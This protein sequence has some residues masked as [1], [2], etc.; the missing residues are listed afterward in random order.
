MGVLLK[1]IKSEWGLIIIITLITLV[2]CDSQEQTTVTPPPHRGAARQMY[3]SGSLRPPGMKPVYVSP[4]QK[5][6]QISQIPIYKSPLP[7]PLF[8]FPIAIPI[9]HLPIPSV[10]H[11]GGKYGNRPEF[12]G[13]IK[14]PP[15]GWYSGELFGKGLL[16]PDRRRLMKISNQYVRHP[17]QMDTHDV[18]LCGG[19]CTR[20]EFL[21]VSSCMCIKEMLRCDGEADCDKNEDEIDCENTMRNNEKCEDLENGKYTRCP[22]TGSC[23]LKSWLCDG[24]DDCGDYTDETHCGESVNCTIDQFECANGLCIPKNWVCDN[25]NDCKDY[26]DESN[27]TKVGCTE[28][29]FTCED[30]SCI[31]L[32]WKCDREPDCDD[33]TD[34]NDCEIQPFMCSEEEFQCIL[35]N[36]CI[37][38]EYKCDG[39]NDCKDWSDEVDCQT[40]L[41]PCLAGEFRC[42][43]GSCIPEKYRCDKQQDCS[44]NEDEAD[45]EHT[46]T[47]I[48]S[49][50]EH[51][52]KDGTCIL[53]TWVCDGVQDCSQ[54]EDELKCEIV[55]DDSKF[56]CSGDGFNDSSTSF[57]INKKHICDGQKDCPKGEDEKNCSTKKPCEKDSV[58]AQDCVVTHDGKDGC[59]CKPGY[60]L[61]Q[62]QKSCDDINECMYQTDPVCSQTCNNTIGSFI[63]GCMTGYILRPDLRSCKALGA[64]PTLLFTNRVD[65]RQVSLSNQKYTFLLKGLHNAIALDYHY[66]K[67]TIFWSDLT[68]DVIKSSY[69]NGTNVKDV[70]KWGL[71]SPGGIALDWVHNLLFWTDSGTRR[72]EVSTLEG[73]ERVI[74]AANDLDKPR[75]ISVHPGEALIFWT[76]WGP[77]P[78]IERSEMDGTNRKSIITDSVFWPNGL[79]LDYTSNR[80]YWADAKHNVIETA[81]FDGSDRRK[82]ISKGLPHPFALTIFEDAIYWTDWHTKSI[83][84]ANKA[85]GAGFRTIH[86]DLHFPMDI[87]SYHSLRQPKYDNHCGTNNGGCAHLCLPN[88]KGFVCACPMG[89]KLTSDGKSCQKPEKLLIFAR[90]KELRIKHLD[91]NAVHSH[92]IIIP[93]DGIK[94]AVALDWDSK[95]DTVFWTDIEKDTINSAHWNGTEQKVIIHT[96]LDS[97][98]GLAYDWITDKIY[99]TDASTKRIEVSNKNGS[100]RSLLIWQDLDKPQD[101]VVDPISGFMYWS[102][103]GDKPKIEKSNMDGSSRTVL[104]KTNISWPNGLAI[105]Y[106][107]G[108]LYWADGKRNSIDSCNLDGT[109]RKTILGPDLPHPFGLDIFGSSLYWTDWK[110]PYIEMADKT[111]GANRNILVSNISDLMDVRIFHRNRKIIETECNKDNG[112]C[113]HLCLLKPKGYSC[114]C[115]LGRVL[116]SDGKTCL[117]NPRESLIL[118][119]RFDIRQISLDV[120]YIIDVVLPFPH[121]KHVV[122]TDFDQNSGMLYWSDSS[123]SV[124]ERASFDGSVIETVLTHELTSVE[125]IAIDSITKK[126]YW[127]D[128]ER[129]S[130]EVAELNGTNRKLL[131][132]S[133][134]DNPRA[135]VLDYEHGMMVWSDWGTHAKIETAEMDGNNRKTIVNENLIWPNGLAIDKD[136]HRIYWSDGSAKIIGSVD[137]KGKKRKVIL[138]ELPHPYG[139]TIFGGYV[140]WTD[141]K[142]KSLHRANKTTG[143]DAVTLCGKL[144]GL[145]DVRAISTGLMHKNVCGSNNGGCSHLCLRNAKGYSCACPTGIKMKSGSKTT[146]NYQPDKYLLFATRSALARI[147]L[148]SPDSWDVTLPIKNINHVINVDFHWGLQIFYFTDVKNQV[149][150]SVNMRNLSDVKTIVHQNGSA[151]Y[152][153]AIDWISNNIYWSDTHYS[154]IQVCKMDGSWR[155]VIIKDD[156]VEPR[157]LAVYPK[158]GYLF[159]TEW[160]KSPKIQRSFLDG[161]GRQTILSKEQGLPNGLV[162]DY[163]EARLYWTDSQLDLIES[164]DLNGRSSMQLMYPKKMTMLTRPFGLALFGDNMYWTDWLDKSLLRAD[165]K[166]GERCVVIRNKLDGAM[167][168]TTVSQERQSGWNPCVVN[169]GGCSHFCFF[170][171]RNYTCGCPDDSDKSCKIVPKE[172]VTEKNPNGIYLYE[173]GDYEA[174]PPALNEIFPEIQKDTPYHKFYILALVLMVS[175]FVL[176]SLLMVAAVI[177]RRSKKKYLYATGRSV[178]TFSNPNYYTPSGEPTGPAVLV[179]KRPCIWKRLKYDKSQDRVYEDKTGGTSPEIASLIPTVLTPSSSNCEAVTPELG[180]SP[181]VTPMHRESQPSV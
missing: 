84:T 68:L 1:N 111:N 81:L 60:Q 19:D 72:I 11:L 78:K 8:R 146:C 74:I 154:I 43:S 31:S 21:C 118:S 113:S 41:D 158:L 12:A 92:E 181:L 90:K 100:I 178:R 131:I 94:S 106:D 53:K 165:R 48:C 103:W 174:T 150:Q 147:S 152:G 101:I 172:W 88:A 63:C 151:P 144:D 82:V 22:R 18:H 36:N 4:S 87:H 40:T 28:D 98:S 107:G 148:D 58:C 177:Y 121:L 104:V 105:D 42:K 97:P 124:I 119:H 14:R 179:D 93:V 59:S 138:G 26:S 176:I 134:L 135:I 6:T 166:T 51:S 10:R 9:D 77:S 157:S 79:T 62:D 37:K 149:I 57:C 175:I 159:W 130:I 115:P 142:T 49:D 33:G 38:I 15:L 168:I 39:D 162:I 171:L 29:E 24:D 109:N 75:A 112:G 141:W 156:I 127:T 71:E 143:R 13:V 54:G 114:T 86:S 69:M 136:F 80:L 46:A 122:S 52:C 108:K 66:D 128:R 73:K 56:P 180:H 91:E 20:G 67:K 170:K 2:Q 126:L 30:G 145:L 45:C 50:D 35:N 155:K 70:I 120:P 89:Q 163:N 102:D 160:G 5:P 125:S 117:E 16:P 153:L 164:S 23:I 123:E 167:G 25:D 129:N 61:G 64:P 47:R 96:N 139:L 110:T 173:N 32:S 116:K 133:D 169:N 132:Y 34:E 99:W 76:D 137:F 83:S 44:E 140:Y 3:G 95:S 55:C 27:C 17:E 7:N 85:T 161:S 65:I